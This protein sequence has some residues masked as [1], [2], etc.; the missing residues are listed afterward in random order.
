MQ[1]AAGYSD[2]QMQARFYHRFQVDVMSA[3]A[4]R[5]KDANALTAEIRKALS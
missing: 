1:L 2:S 5:P 3:Q 4:L